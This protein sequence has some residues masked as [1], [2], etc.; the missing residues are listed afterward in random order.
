MRGKTSTR[1]SVPT[2]IL[3]RHRP[4]GEL[5]PRIREA[6]WI[7]SQRAGVRH[8]HYGRQIAFPAL[9]GTQPLSQKY[10][11]ICGLYEC[12]ITQTTRTAS[13]GYSRSS[14]ARSEQRGL[15]TYDFCGHRNGG[16]GGHITTGRGPSSPTAS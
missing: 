5:T 13:P 6:M 1:I 14:V 3:R 11:C 10:F 15:L 16:Q 9:R 7:M 12:R 4:Q 2:C 8:W